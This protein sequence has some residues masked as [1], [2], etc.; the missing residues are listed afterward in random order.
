MKEFVYEVR[1]VCTLIKNNDIYYPSANE[2]EIITQKVRNNNFLGK[3]YHIFTPSLLT[4]KLDCVFYDGNELT[5]N[6]KVFSN[7]CR[8]LHLFENINNIQTYNWIMSFFIKRNILPQNVYLKFN[9][10][11]AYIGLIIDGYLRDY[12][13]NND[14]NF[15]NTV[16]KY[17]LNYKI[18]K[19]KIISKY[20]V[21]DLSKIILS[22]F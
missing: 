21:D 8:S 10:I 16:E 19:K 6:Y 12:F 14:V 3:K 7:E 5:L 9:N 17:Y 13:N 20:F 2:R 1:I 4:N 22:Y 15:V 11:E 18:N